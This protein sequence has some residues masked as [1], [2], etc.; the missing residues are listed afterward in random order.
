MAQTSEEQ[1][2]KE[3]NQYVRKAWKLCDCCHSDW[4]IRYILTWK[5]KTEKTPEER[6]L[7][8]DS[9]IHRLKI[10]WIRRKSTSCGNPEQVKARNVQLWPRLLVVQKGGW[11]MIYC[12]MLYD[13]IWYDMIWYECELS[14]KKKWRLKNK[15]NG[16]R[17][18]PPQS[19]FAVCFDVPVSSV[20][21]PLSLDDVMYASSSTWITLWS[22]QSMTAI[23][24]AANRASWR[25]SREESNTVSC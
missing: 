20:T 12:M 15:I 7:L 2:Q 6:V 9:R 14:L 24:P 21:H 17:T 1:K 3:T 4:P 5:V 18:K 8:R 13:T 22:P 11:D 16:W 25:I 19:R 23:A 10:V